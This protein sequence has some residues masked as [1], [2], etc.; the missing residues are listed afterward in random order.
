MER[1]ET[2]SGP[3]AASPAAPGD[4]MESGSDRPAEQPPAEA[5][6]SAAAGDAIGPGAAEPVRRVDA[7]AI[8]AGAHPDTGARSPGSERRNAG[9]MVAGY[10]LAA[11]AGVALTV[12]AFVGSGIASLGPSPTPSAE[13]TYAVTGPSVG[14]ASAPVTIEVWADYQCPYCGIFTHGIEPTLLRDYAATGRAL[15]AF[16]DFAF[17]GQESIDAAVAARCAGREGRYWTYHDLLYTS[18][19]GENQGAFARQNLDSLATFAGLDKATFDTC[20]AD[21]AV[22]RD[23]AAETQAGRG[24]GIESTPTLRITGPGGTKLVKGITKPEDIA[25]TIAAVATVAPPTPPGG[26]TRSGGPGPSGSPGSSGG[27]GPS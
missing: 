21:P 12:V 14:V 11:L 8:D 10:V 27:P 17:L 26:P 15:V 24:L 13:S 7:G 16:R 4:A 5:S 25:A 6:T 23:V 20:L 3:E 1:D 18:Q 2:G 19:R 22:A 9:P